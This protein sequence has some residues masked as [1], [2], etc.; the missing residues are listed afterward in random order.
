MTVAELKVLLDTLP[1]R[2]DTLVVVH[3]PGDY[4]VGAVVDV[5]VVT[6]PGEDLFF[7]VDADESDV[8]DEKFVVLIFG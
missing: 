8:D 7:P 6:S 3:V 4:Y 5:G 2:D 1:V